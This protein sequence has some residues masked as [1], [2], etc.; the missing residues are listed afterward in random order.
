M[1]KKI[2]GLCGSLR[3]GSYNRR[4]MALV[5]EAMGDDVQFEEVA[6]NWP[7]YDGDVEEKDGVPQQVLTAAAAIADADA[8]I[9]ASPEYNKGITGV[10]KNA[11]DWLSRTPQKP[12]ANKPVAFVSAA[13]GR[14]GGETAQYMT[15]ACVM[16]LGAHI[17][18][19]PPVLVAG[20]FGEFD[21][22]GNLT[23]EQYIAAI[24]SMADALNAQLS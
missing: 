9:I 17:V 6:L 1:S 18:N 3:A 8:V 24:Q 2:I 4:V 22:A 20:V 15:K 16:T 19:L 10:L 14:T 7:L 13:A 12:F 23:N 11:L 5:A 21:E